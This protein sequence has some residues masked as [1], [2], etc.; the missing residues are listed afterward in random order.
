MTL[1][2]DADLAWSDLAVSG[3]FAPFMH[4]VVRY[5]STGSFGTDDVIVGRRVA[6]PVRDPDA[7]DAV[8]QPPAGPVQ[9]VWAQQRGDRSYW[10]IEE[11]EIPGVWDVYSQERVVDRFAARNISHTNGIHLQELRLHPVSMVCTVR[12]ILL[13][14]LQLTNESAGR[15]KNHGQQSEGCESDTRQQINTRSN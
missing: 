6:R 5:L 4:R 2:S 3:F 12:V 13:S 8:V 7:R 15:Q 14:V 11:V 9:T 10:M 1:L